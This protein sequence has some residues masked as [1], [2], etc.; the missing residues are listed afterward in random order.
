MVLRQ[1]AAGRISPAAAAS[2]LAAF[3]SQTRLVEAKEL[4][5]RPAAVEAKLEEKQS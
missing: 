4:E 1:M 5:A 2:A 3:T